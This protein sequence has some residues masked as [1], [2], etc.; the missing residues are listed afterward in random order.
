[1]DVAGVSGAGESGVA[2]GL[3]VLVV[4]AGSSSLKLRLLDPADQITG[5][6]DLPAPRGIPEAEAVRQTLAGLDRKSVV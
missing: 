1:V 4:N 2:G 3:R 5:S 6:A